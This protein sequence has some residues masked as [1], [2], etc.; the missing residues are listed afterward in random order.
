MSCQAIVPS[1][2]CPYN[3]PSVYQHEIEANCVDQWHP[4]SIPAG[5]P[6]TRGAENGETRMRSIKRNNELRVNLQLVYYLSLS[7]HDL[8][9]VTVIFR[10]VKGH[11]IYSPREQRQVNQS[12][13]YSKNNA[14]IFHVGEVSEL[15]RRTMVNNSQL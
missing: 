5:H 15:G 3:L 4:R 10:L 6:E 8:F 9:F 13:T 1:Y 7:K 11:A 14:H 2:S 12:G